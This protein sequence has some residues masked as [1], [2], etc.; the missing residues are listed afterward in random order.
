M[1]CYRKA[2]KLNPR[3]PA[4]HLNLGISLLRMGNKVQARTHLREFLALNP[5]SPR[6]EEI[7]R[8]L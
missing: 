1:N 4:T 5:S 8:W 6:R 7:S 2:L 3:D